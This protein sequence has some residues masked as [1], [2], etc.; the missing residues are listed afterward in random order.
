MA[1]YE[2]KWGFLRIF[3][4]EGAAMTKTKALTHLRNQH[5]FNT[6]VLPMFAD[7]KLWGRVARRGPE[8]KK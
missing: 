7:G 2:W 8:T 1:I 4:K 5:D 6:I 3:Q